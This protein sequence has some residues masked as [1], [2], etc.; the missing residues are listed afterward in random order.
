GTL[1]LRGTTG[2]GPFERT[3]DVTLPGDEPKDDVLASLWARAKVEH[4]MDRDLAGI[5]S[6]KPDP[7]MEEE[8]L[9]LGL[10]Y[11]LLTQYTSFV[12]VEHVRITEG[13]QAR[14]VTVPV[15][16]PEGVSHE[17]V[18]GTRGQTV[19][20]AFFYGMPSLGKSAGGMGGGAAAGMR[21]GRAV[22]RAVAPQPMLNKSPTTRREA[23]DRM[24]AALAE[25]PESKLAPE[26][27]GL[28]EEVAEKG[29]DGNLTVGKIEVKAGRVEIRV[30]LGALSDDALAKL[31]ALGFKELA[32]AK[33]VKLVIGTIDVGKLEALVNL[34]VVRRVDPSL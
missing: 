19:N 7:A 23:V 31:K 21:L 28:A 11:Q 33:S 10:R 27:K 29:A 1:T 32:R 6:G 16:M 20:Q 5:Q 3:I 24:A 2:E 25:S 30:R 26:L 4:L 14:T 8:I 13:G 9:G 17:G 15:E 18:F 22:R 12:A 34:D